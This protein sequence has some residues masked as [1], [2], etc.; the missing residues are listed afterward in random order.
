MSLFGQ[1]TPNTLLHI[2]HLIPVLDILSLGQVGSVTR[3]NLL[4]HKHH[5]PD[6]QVL[7]YLLATTL[8]MGPCIG[9]ARR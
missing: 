6:M 9:R 5:R 4:D 2:I 7:T 8:N 3:S 1:L